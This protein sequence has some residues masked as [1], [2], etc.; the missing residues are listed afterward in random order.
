MQSLQKTS[1]KYFKGLIQRLSIDAAQLYTIKHNI[2]TWRSW[3]QQ[4]TSGE[5]LCDFM[6]IGE[7]SIA[8]SYFSNIIAR[9]LNAKIIPFSQK[10][11]YWYLSTWLIY[12]SFNA[13]G[14]VFCLHLS[15]AQK[16]KRDMIYSAA[17]ETINTKQD[18]IDFK[19]EGLMI[20]LDIYETYLRERFQPTVNLDDP[21]FWKTFKDGI[22]IL[23]FWQDYFS[24]HKVVSVIVSHDAYMSMNL[25]CKVAYS[26]KIPVYTPSVRAFYSLD[27][28]FTT[29]KYLNDFPAMFK[30]LSPAEQLDGIEW[31][32]ERLQLKFGGEVGVDMS[33]S[34][35]TGFT[36]KI[37]D[38]K[39]L[40]VSQK[41]KI[42]IATHCFYDNP[43]A[44]GQLI[45][46]DFY[47]WLN[48]LGKLS[49]ETNYDWYIKSH[50]DP[51]PETFEVLKE[52][53]TRYPDISVLPHDT[54]H[55]QIIDEGI[56]VVLTGYGSIGH[57]YPYFGIPV[58]NCAFNPHIAYNFN[59]HVKTVEEY[60]N[61][62]LN[63]NNFQCKIDKEEIFEFYFMNNKYILADDLMLPSY[64]KF[65]NDLSQEERGGFAG[66]KYFIN[67]LTEESHEN[68]ILKIENYID[69]GK[70][71]YFRYGP[72]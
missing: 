5:I 2:K 66:F 27:A 56:N 30:T 31:A 55:L 21:I 34:T 4:V 38:K 64:S 22:G 72:I 51:L 25:I 24:N 36:N 69:S 16:N 42:L 33:Y 19:V 39:V 62:L 1:K 14:M 32:K 46:P 70:R 10:Y 47:E 52:I 41:L 40:R 50:P 3:R 37:A 6:S 45:F 20:G 68:I 71:W 58:I 11:R 59:Y 8:F 35:K 60:K 43:H 57:E 26:Q 13:K 15:K 54:S 29:H 18:V 9:R 67:H 63:L 17:K 7:S 48:F 12:K 65:L 49:E 23:I 53:T 61:V 44:L 28:Q